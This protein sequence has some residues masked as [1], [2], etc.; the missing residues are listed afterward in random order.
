MLVV[1]VIIVVANNLVVNARQDQLL[2]AVSDL[3][4]H[5]EVTDNDSLQAVQL[6]V[7]LLVLTSISKSTNLLEIV[8][9]SKKAIEYG[10]Y[11]G[12]KRP[13]TCRTVEIHSFT[14]SY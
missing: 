5:P 14:P 11:S 7:V 2:A 4:L 13:N 8:I 10:R 12:S 3:E 6:H 9:A 1:V